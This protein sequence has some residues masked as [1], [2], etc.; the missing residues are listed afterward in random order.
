MT[1]AHPTTETITNRGEVMNPPVP[2]ARGTEA[3][4]LN[5][6]Q[7]HG[8]G[9]EPQGMEAQATQPSATPFQMGYGFAYFRSHSR[10]HEYGSWLVPDFTDSM[11]DDQTNYG[12]CACGDGYIVSNQ[13]HWH[14]SD[15]K[16]HN[17]VEC[18]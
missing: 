18:K 1:D 4:N 10:A 17:R 16:C 5:T 9:V 6:P 11:I 2:A 15:G 3:R 7:R 12:D 13:Y 14:A 8:S